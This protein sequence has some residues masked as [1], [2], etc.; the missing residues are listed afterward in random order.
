MAFVCSICEEQ[1]TRICVSCTKD[2][3]GNHLCEKCKRCSD[4]CACV[5]GLDDAR[6]HEDAQKEALKVAP[7]EA[8]KEAP[9]ES[10]KPAGTR[11]GSADPPPG[12]VE[13]FR[14]SPGSILSGVAE[15]E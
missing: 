9:K 6:P 10:A 5:I 12:K 14:H 8:L 15:A 3:C 7:K 4:C 13:V 11:P 1:S 2:A